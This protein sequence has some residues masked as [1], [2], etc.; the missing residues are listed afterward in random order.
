MRRN[1]CNLDDKNLKAMGIKDKFGTPFIKHPQGRNGVQPLRFHR[2]TG[3]YEN[4]GSR[5]RMSCQR[6]PPRAGGLREDAP[7]SGRIW[8]TL[9]VPSPSSS[10]AG[11]GGCVG[12]PRHPKQAPCPAASGGPRGGEADA[13]DRRSKG[14]VNLRG[15]A[16]SPERTGSLRQ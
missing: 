1:S 11:Q 7:A 15:G 12:G 16:S 14:T 4:E 5:R 6:P 3:R 8:G 10:A 9:A 2:P 13:G